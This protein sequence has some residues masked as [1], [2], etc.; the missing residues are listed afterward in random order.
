MQNLLSDQQTNLAG[1]EL[2]KKSFP[3][4]RFML[5]NRIANVILVVVVVVVA[6]KEVVVRPIVIVH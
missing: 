1:L 3:I 6:I 2:L 5:S 4:Q